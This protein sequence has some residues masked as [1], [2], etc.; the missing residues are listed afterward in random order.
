MQN[1]NRS[2]S[3]ILWEKFLDVVEDSDWRSLFLL[4]ARFFCAIVISVSLV[5]VR[6]AGELF[7]EV[8]RW[9]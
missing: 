3:G 5:D 6:A 8:F 2:L 9:N 1:I 4:L 7:L